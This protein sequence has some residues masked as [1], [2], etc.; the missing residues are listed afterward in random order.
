M[1]HIG[2]ISQA[3]SAI[4]IGSYSHIINSGYFNNVI[5]MIN[6]IFNCCQRPWITC[7]SLLPGSTCF[8]HSGIAQVFKIIVCSPHGFHR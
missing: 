1:S 4:K 5:N 3:A 6:S 2:A 7:I 8:F